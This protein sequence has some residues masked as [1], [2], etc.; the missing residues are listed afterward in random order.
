MYI[1]IGGVGMMGADLARTL[2]EMGYTI[3]VIDTDPLVCQ[4]ARE[5][6]RFDYS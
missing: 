6:R 5:K 3:A 2:L 1:L 4:Y